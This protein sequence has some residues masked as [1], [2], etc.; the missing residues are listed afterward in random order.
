VGWL[1]ALH[2]M[3]E[4]TELGLGPSEKM[5]G[6]AGELDEGALFILSPDA[7]K[8][9]L[10]GLLSPPL[11]PHLSP[12]HLL[13]LPPIVAA[14]QKEGVVSVVVGESVARAKLD[15]DLAWPT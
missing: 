11:R 9:S 8:T 15:C 10:S 13:T 7:A 4:P 6:R 2:E 14:T 3:H 12:A 1:R 5:P